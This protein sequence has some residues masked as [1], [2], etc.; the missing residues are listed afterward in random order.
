VS[1]PISEGTPDQISTALC[2]IILAPELE[3]AF[4][5]ANRRSLSERL[6]LLV[7]HSQSTN[8]WALQCLQ[9]INLRLG[10]KHIFAQQ[11]HGQNRKNIPTYKINTFTYA[12]RF[13]HFVVQV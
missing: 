13:W 9:S 10:G 12:F 8:N 5:K 3:R 11:P 1:F 6:L 2:L 4:G 7:K